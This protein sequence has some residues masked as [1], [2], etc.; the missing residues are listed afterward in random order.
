MLE[1]IK[2]KL[3]FLKY[4]DPFYYVD[5]YLVP[6]V[7]PKNTEWVNWAIYFVS[8]LFF[9]WLIYTL[10]GVVLATHSPMVIVVS[11]SMEPVLYR[12][13]V[14][15]MQGVSPENINAPLT[16]INL[17]TLRETGLGEI[18]RVD[19]IPPKNLLFA[20]GEAIPITEKGDTV[21]YI[22]TSLRSLGEPVIHRVVAKVKAGDGYYLVTKG[23]NN[24][25]IDQDC[26]KVIAGTSQYPC[27]TLYPIPATEISGR[28]V[29]KIPLI[30]YV[31]LLLFDDLPALIFGCRV[32]STSTFCSRSA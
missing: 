21:V 25:V 22:S 8:A 28:A 4:L 20:N 27:I 14:V 13:D 26:G 12:G 30:G 2:Q 32:G 18:A 23:D 11:G 9:A 16:T 7:N 3:Q 29:F 5:T 19:A 1:K 6:K 31:K 24:N 15:V 17:P 10:L